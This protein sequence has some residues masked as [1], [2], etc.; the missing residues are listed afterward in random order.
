MTY[1]AST[2]VLNGIPEGFSFNLV[3]IM[4][5]SSGIGRLAAG[6]IG[7]RIGPMNH[8]IPS[9]IVSGLVIL[10]WPAVRSQSAFIAVVV[11]FGFTA[12]SYSALLWQPILDLGD[13]DELSR[14]VGIMMIFLACAGFLGPPTAGEVNNAAGMQAMTIYAGGC[15]LVGVALVLVARHM[16]LK[17]VFGKI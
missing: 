10:A 5:G 1:V 6:I 14:R 7:N 16:M 13:A 15:T 9:T 4:N 17:K 8:M 3:A 11:V 2:A 12:G